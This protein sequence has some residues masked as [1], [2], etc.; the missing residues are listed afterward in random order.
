[1]TPLAFARTR[2][3]P[4]PSGYLH[5]GNLFSFLLATELAKKANAEVLL[6]IDDI[7]APRVEEAYL[8]NIFE[9]LK[10]F[11]IHW[12]LGPQN[13]EE[14]QLHSQQTR[15]HL[16]RSTLEN[17][18]T[19][20]LL[21]ACDCSRHSVYERTGSAQY[22]GHCRNKNIPFTAQ[23]VAWRLKC[24]LDASILLRNEEGAVSQHPL[25]EKMRDFIVLRRDGIPAYQLSSFC[26]DLLYGV[27][28]VVRGEDLFDSSLAQLHLSQLLEDTTFQK[29]RF[30][31][32]PL[33]RDRNGNKLSKSE[34]ADCVKTMLDKGFTAQQIIISLADKLPKKYADNILR[35]EL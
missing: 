2:I 20:G 22:D 34:N 10:A 18:K 31:H 1:M 24:N 3:A 23:N 4:T 7:D 16:Y 11:S 12:Q 33:L 9:V 13:F 26:D 27:D 6:R 30:L 25:P 21:Y 35:H 29:V 5:L 14:V 15:L 32:H 8:K 17:L 19:K 28:F